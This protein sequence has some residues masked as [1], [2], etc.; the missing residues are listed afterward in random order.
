MNR[1]VF[2]YRFVLD[3]GNKPATRKLNL[4]CVCGKARVDLS[5]FAVCNLYERKEWK[6]TKT[7][8]PFKILNVFIF[9][10]FV[11]GRVKL[12]TVVAW[13]RIPIR[14]YL[15]SPSTPLQ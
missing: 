2:S 15:G 9:I 8:C 13:L 4:L 10:T 11:S 7:I 1:S 14:I 12:A 6:N 3:F 5:T